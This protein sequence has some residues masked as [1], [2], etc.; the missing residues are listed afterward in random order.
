MESRQAQV[1]HAA[2]LDKHQ[3]DLERH[4]LGRVALMHDGELINVFND[5]GD[6]YSIGCEKYG[7]G[8][9]SIETIGARPVHLGI[10]TPASA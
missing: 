9:F 4:S 10:H 6:V 3:R 1:N 7:L 5:E 2:Y 8:G